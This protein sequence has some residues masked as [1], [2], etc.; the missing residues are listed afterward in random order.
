MAK[1]FWII[2]KVAQFRQIWSPW[3][4]MHQIMS[5]YLFFIPEIFLILNCEGR[6]TVNKVVLIG[7]VM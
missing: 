1:D 4:H 6:K 3:S 5:Q 7:F 2:A